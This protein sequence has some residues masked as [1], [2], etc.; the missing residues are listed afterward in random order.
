MC[1]ICECDTLHGVHSGSDFLTA[2][3]RARREMDLA[4]SAMLHCSQVASS[5]EARMQYAST[6]KRMRAMIRD[7]NRL[8]QER[9]VADGHH[10][11]TISTNKKGGT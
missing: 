1:I 10:P 9:E 3:G 2:Y 5:R 8:E 11:D 6:H 4:A 7:W